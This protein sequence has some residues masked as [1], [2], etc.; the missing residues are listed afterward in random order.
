MGSRTSIISRLAFLATI[1]ALL[2]STSFFVAFSKYPGDLWPRPLVDL[3]YYSGSGAKSLGIEDV[4]HERPDDALR[5]RSWEMSLSSWSHDQ[6]ARLIIEA[7]SSDEQATE[8]KAEILGMGGNVTDTLSIGRNSHFLTVKLPPDRTSLFAE[9]L[10]RNGLVK[11]IELDSRVEASYIPNDPSWPDQWG[12]QKIEAS[13][14]WDKTIG[15]SSVLVAIVD[16]GID[17]THEELAANYVPLGYDWVNND[18]DP[19]DDHGHGTHCAGIVAAKINNALGIAGLAQVR[20]M[21][22]KVLGSDG[23]GWDSWVAA[24]IVHA[25]DCGA[26][27]ISMSLVGS[28][29]SDLMHDAVQ[30][31]SSQGVLVVAA[32]GNT[33]TTSPGYPAAYEEVV[34]VSATDQS[35]NLA[36]FSTFGEWIDLSAPGVDIY[37]TVLGNSY[38]YFSGT[39]MACPHVSGVAA[40][41]W[42]V[43][44]NCTANQIRWILEHTTDDLGYPGFDRMYGNGRVNAR[45]AVNLPQHDV[46]IAGCKYPRRV[47]PE[48][49]CMFNVAVANYGIKN[50]VNVNVRFF[51]NEVQKDSITISQLDAFSSTN[52]TFSWNTTNTG[53]HK[54]KFEVVPVPGE[55]LTQNN[56]A[57]Y[58]LAVR[59]P[60]TL[61]VPEDYP[62]IKAALNN[63]GDGDTV[64]VSEGYYD[65]GQIDILTDNFTLAADGIVFLDGFRGYCTLNIIADFVTIEGFDIENCSAYGVSMKGHGNV[66]RNNY[67]VHNGESLR[68]YDSSGCVLS[69]N[70]VHTHSGGMYIEN[71]WNN[72]ITRTRVVSDSLAGGIHLI[73]SSNNTVSFN[74][75]TGVMKY[76]LE[77]SY[78]PN[79]IIVSNNLVGNRY[80]LILNSSPYNVLRNNTMSDNWCNFVPSTGVVSYSWSGASDVDASNTVDGKPICYWVNVSDRTVPSDAG[81]VLLANCR[82]II[83]ENLELKNNYYGILLVNSS[84]IL[85]RQNSI[86]DNW[87]NY[88]F[89]CGGIY[90]DDKSWDIMIT[91]NNVTANKDGIVLW[92]YNNTVSFNYIANNFDTGIEVGSDSVVSHNT[93]ISNQKNGVYIS[94]SNCLVESNNIMSGLGPG[95]VVSGSNHTIF[96]NNII[97]NGR[98]TEN[99]YGTSHFGMYTFFASNC[100][101]SKN[102]VFQWDN[103]GMFM[104]ESVGNQIFHNNFISNNQEFWNCG[105][106]SS[107]AWDDGY[108]SGGNY[109]SSY[110]GTD[111]NEDGIGDT[112]YSFD[113]NNTDQYPLMTPWTENPPP[114]V[115]TLVVGGIIGEQPIQGFYDTT[116]PRPGAYFYVADSTIRVDTRLSN[117]TY[118]DHWELDGA[119]MSSNSFVTLT[120]DRDHNLTVSL[121]VLSRI[122]VSISP[123]TARVK[124]GG[125]I[126]FNSSVSGGKPPYEHLWYVDGREVWN[127]SSTLAFTSR[128][129]GNHTVQLMVRYPFS[130]G[131]YGTFQQSETAIVTVQIP[132]DV[133]GDFDVDILDAILLSNAFNSKP[134]EPAWSPNAD[135]NGDGSVNILDAIILSNHFNEKEP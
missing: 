12:P 99:I 58:D 7:D 109:W 72:T 64:L 54:I 116:Y 118:V 9:E 2:L 63:S 79:N 13:A 78:S 92:G 28:E 94:G 39:S 117:P 128:K 42:S 29:W 124:F 35:D 70:Y 106:S 51:V 10:R 14:A 71:S 43:Y 65:E 53:N 49:P 114:Q 16:T 26:E 5:L 40:L 74:N 82:N 112:P 23:G 19:I 69:Q 115:V 88:D 113:V 134:G 110:N 22:E 133:D 62:T 31:A 57:Y 6:S 68:L 75:V 129:S 90:S 76:A 103:Y 47:D 102:N 111:D 122:N 105:N 8:L 97:A 3:S 130:A 131:Y 44:P 56:I 15:S 85:I 95:I 98:P 37:S 104:Y 120:M 45:K 81:C 123:M 87:N 66:L 1:L 135:I 18:T 27:I 48:R 107:S 55:T 41:A 83:A 20:I 60:T 32:A 86:R 91:S 34:A 108:P 77:F 59:F 101:I 96:S 36:W 52:V 33:G 30:Y 25:T 125:S 67:I 73:S 61:K 4:A 126:T 11:N 21:A 46:C 132:G 84:S 100:T 89:L 121:C 127:A 50:E 93:I 38:A 80:G 24:G 119:N 17:Y